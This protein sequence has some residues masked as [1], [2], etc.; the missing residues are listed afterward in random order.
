MSTL[1]R[2]SALK[3]RG[4]NVRLVSLNPLGALSSRLAAEGIPA[5][6]LQYRGRWGWKSIPAMWREFRA[7]PA[8]AIFMH[9]PN[10]S[11]MLALGLICK[12]R[13][14]LGVHFHHTG[15]KPRLSWYLLYLLA[16]K[17]FQYVTFPTQFIRQEA[18]RIYPR[19]EA[20]S[21]VVPNHF[22]VE[23]LPPASQRRLARESLGI[24]L[25]A[26]VV[27]N[28]GWLIPRKRFDVFL[29]TAQ[30]LSGRFPD[31]VF[32]IA[33][34]GPLR[35]ELQ[36]QAVDLGI[37]D[38]VRWLGW[39][40]DLGPFYQSLDVLLFNTDWDAL[41]R[42]PIEALAAGVPTVA[43]VING[44]LAEMVTP[45]ECG[46]LLDR[47]DTDWL[48]DRTAEL[49]ERPEVGTRMVETMRARLKELCNPSVELACLEKVIA[50]IQG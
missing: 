21:G 32:L 23:E 2:M 1:A 25:S 35:A 33:G 22:D 40:Q 31:I 17:V 29:E 7:L 43:S 26:R 8:D 9:G 37:S 14:I 3:A 18:I 15:V 36:R 44:G 47:H 49:L 10:V 24:P 19:I 27:G 13:R 6:G 11:A 5:S 34:D 39:Q 20:M 28:A 16:S 45:D 48:A 46:Y 38:R 30:K 12:G 42:T 50:S 41:G 4:H